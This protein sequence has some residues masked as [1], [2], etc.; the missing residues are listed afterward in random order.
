MYCKSCGN[1]LDAQAKFCTNCGS[2]LEPVTAPTD[3]KST[4]ANVLESSPTLP[5]ADAPPSRSGVEDRD[6]EDLYLFVGTKSSTYRKKWARLD[7]ASPFSKLSWNWSAFLFGSYW[8]AYRKMYL[9]AIILVVVSL[10]ISLFGTSLWGFGMI[11][12]WVARGLWSNGAYLSFVKR[13]VDKIKSAHSDPAVQR[14]L[15]VK[16]GG[17]SAIG[18][19]VTIVLYGLLNGASAFSSQQASPQQ[20]NSVTVG[21]QAENNQSL[22]VT[23]THF[24][25]GGPFFFNFTD[26]S[27]FGTTKLT[28]LLQQS[29]GN[30]AWSIIDEHPLLV[31]PQDGV[32]QAPFTIEN[33]G[34]YEL[35]ILNGNTVL[36][37]TKFK[38]SG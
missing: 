23:G 13:K 29:D 36:A 37:D 21:T 27:A 1:E 4:Q 38:V 11:I 31:D 6:D 30:G 19:T 10:A 24:V 25:A 34:T 16:E 15:I 22:S 12:I 32:E 17:T 35:S 5:S 14:T 28:F 18:L 33:S 26:G 9:Y 20:T 3:A 2:P 7:P 8:L